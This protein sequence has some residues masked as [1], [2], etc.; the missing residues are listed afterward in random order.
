[1]SKT[2]KPGYLYPIVGT[3]LV[4]FVLGVFLLITLHTRAFVNTLKEN[5]DVWV[6]MHPDATP[7]QAAQLIARVSANTSV[8]PG[9]VKWMS[10]EE[11][12]SQIKQELGDENMLEDLPSMMRDVVQ[13]HVRANQLTDQGMTTL[14]EEMKSDSLVSEIFFETANAENITSNMARISQIAIALALILVIISIVLIHNTVRLALYT[15]RLL[16]KNMQLVGATNAFIRSPY[17]WRAAVNGLW[18]ALIAIGLLIACLYFIQQ[19]AKGIEEIQANWSILATFATL[20]VTGL[21]ISV[22]ST[23]FTLQKYLNTRVEEL[24]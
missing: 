6:E 13:F 10:R 15:N 19:Y 20:L 9:S 4:L 17:L 23:W 3:A 12:A 5:V 24:Y 14:K 11:A 8:V 1:M 18:S 7:D 21:V 22:L 2:S 16:V